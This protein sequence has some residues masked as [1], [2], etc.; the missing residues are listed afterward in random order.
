MQRRKFLQTAGGIAAAGF[1]RK[2]SEAAPAAK[3]QSGY[4]PGRIANEYSL[5]LP[6]EKEALA[7]APKV[8]RLEHGAVWVEG[9]SQGIHP[10]QVTGGW[11]LL[12]VFEINGTET[13]IFERNVTHQGA[14]IY[15][16]ERDG[17]ILRIP[18][19]L[20]HLSHVRPR[21]INAKTIQF[22]REAP[23][24]PGPDRLAEYILQSNEDPCYENVA[25]FGAEYIGWTLVGNEQGG[26]LVSLFL[27]PDGTSRQL[28]QSE[29]CK[30]TWAPDHVDAVFDPS[31]HY[32]GS[33]PE[34]YRYL[35]GFSKRTLLGG[36]LPVA[37]T[38]VWNAEA[39]C[40]YE[41]IVAIPPGEEAKPVARVRAM[42][43]D[44]M[45][46]TGDGVVQLGKERY[47]DQYAGTS[48]EGF[49]AELAGIANQWQ[50]FFEDRMKV[51]IPDPWLLDAARAG[52]VLAR[53]SYRGLRPTYQIGEGAYTKIPERSHA[54]FPVAHYEFIWAQQLW[55]LTR[56]S[57]PYFQHYLDSYILPDGNFLY[58]TQDQVEAPLNAGVF[59]WNSARAYDYTRD[60]EALKK[61]LPVLERMIGYV[62][63]RY[64]YSKRTFPVSDRRHGLIWGSPEADL[65][66]PE[67]DYPNSHPYYYQNAAWTWRGLTEHAR[68]LRLA[69][70]DHHASD[71]QEA[72]DKYDGIAKEMRGLVERSMKATIAAGNAAMREA[73]ITPFTPHDTDRDPKHLSSYENHRFMMDW[74]T[75]DWGVEALDVGHLKHRTLAG[76]QILGLH[77]D[78]DWP[79]TSNFMSH[80]TL[81]VRIRQ[82]DYR[83]FLLTLYALCC[84]AADSGNRYSPEDAFLPGSYP[85]EGNKYGWSAVVN[86]VLQPS[87]GLRWLLCYEESGQ[88]VC[89]L[90]KAAPKH[91]F[92]SGERIRVEHCPTRF[93]ELSWNTEAVSNGE[94]RVHIQPPAH[95]SAQLVVHVH[96]PDGRPLASATAGTVQHDRVSIPASSLQ[97][98]R[99]LQFTIR[100]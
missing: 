4:A 82:D 38:G 66:D 91:W 86:S 20:G 11:L 94:W 87:L 33:Y 92:A 61:R 28:N 50:H 74:F 57:D 31:H 24:R 47:R 62:L 53:C 59:L 52:I 34:L 43:P 73:Q 21:P 25:A 55:N 80:G 22:T 79:R 42:L 12:S 68:C 95:F 40:G 81:A 97:A 69:G 44:W 54:L 36:Y 37:N 10:G 99:A 85:G 27:E 83:P 100:T 72:A 16:T 51:E 77:T 39:K 6:G 26:P 29:G 18:K 13:A 75:S 30:A 3:R 8:T 19:R 17:V 2:N 96:P 1:F 7:R 93:G 46:E 67:N 64:E 49:L 9:A 5:F 65:G 78:G 45:H 90:Q 70:G 58:N 15:I 88:D 23:Y 63:D 56:E 89:H 71:L 41:V 14:I 76:E 84:Y 98:G 32:P 60:Y 48:R 35:P